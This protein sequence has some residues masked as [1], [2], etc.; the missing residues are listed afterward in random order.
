[1]QITQPMTDSAWELLKPRLLAQHARAEKQ[2]REQNMIED[3]IGEEDNHSPKESL[4]PSDKNWEACQT[5]IRKNLSTIADDYI[6]TKWARGK[7]ITKETAPQFA[8]DLLCHVRRIFYDSVV[9]QD[10]AALAAGRPI[11]YDVPGEP[12]TRTLILENMKWIY[13]HKIKPRTDRFQPELFLCA[14]C[15]GS[16]KFYG[17][18]G[19]VQHFAAKHTSS[20]SLG[21]SVVH[22]RAEWPEEPMYKSDSG[23]ARAVLPGV[24]QNYGTVTADCGKPVN[25]GPSPYQYIASIPPRDDGFYSAPNPRYPSHEPPPYM[26]QNHGSFPPQ[27]NGY[28][29]PPPEYASYLPGPYS[30]T[31]FSPGYQPPAYSGPP[32]APY[33][34]SHNH[35]PPQAM[36]QYSPPPYYGH[37]GGP[38]GQYNPTGPPPQYPSTFPPHHRPSVPPVNNSVPQ[39]RA[40]GS[41]LYAKQ[42]D[43]MAK[44]AREMW[45]ATNGIK[46]IPQSVRIYAVIHHMSL[47]YAALYQAEPTLAMFQEGLNNDAKMRPVRS[48]NGIGCN[49]CVIARREADLGHRPAVPVGIG[50][51]RLFTLPLLLNHFRN[52]HVE[53][54]LANGNLN[55]PDWKREMIELPELHVISELID[56]VGMDDGKLT[57]LAAAFPA[58]FPSPLPRVGSSTIP[59]SANNLLTNGLNNSRSVQQYG[60]QLG[61]LVGSAPQR[62]SDT[63]TAQ[64]SQPLLQTHGNNRINEAPREDE[65]DPHR[66]AN[67]Q[68]I[69]KSEPNS[70]RLDGP[71]NNIVGGD[72]LQELSRNLGSY[73]EKYHKSHISLANRDNDL[74][75]ASIRSEPAHPAADNQRHEHGFQVEVQ[76]AKPSPTGKTQYSHRDLSNGDHAMRKFKIEDDTRAHERGLSNSDDAQPYSPK[77][78]INGS[79]HEDEYR[80]PS[81][82][83]A[84]NLSGNSNSVSPRRPPR[85]EPQDRDYRHEAGEVRYVHNPYGQDDEPVGIRTSVPRSRSRSPRPAYIIGKSLSPTAS[86]LRNGPRGDSFYR[87]ASPPPREETRSQR[88]IRYEYDPQDRYAYVEDSRLVE[89][90]PRQ[91]V[92]YVPIGGERQ[93]PMEHTRYVYTEPNNSRQR[94]TEYIHYDGA[95]AGD[96]IYEHNGQLYRAQAAHEPLGYTRAYRY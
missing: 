83:E 49:E 27:S 5:L 45:F 47:R 16:Y 30:H 88:L 37:N 40:Q 7:Q 34:P 73:Q 51:R 35:Y 75:Q 14:G 66:P 39:R 65:Y 57:L 95:Y 67:L 21:N 61:S 8:A 42:L 15:P 43:D 80:P 31:D 84:S 38:P 33:Y 23:L 69:I 85:Y 25:S 86:Q 91:R 76:Q 48:L 94:P 36:P 53:P 2:E 79:Q 44:F 29:P 68:T 71:A 24:S 4:D 58:A 82:I 90:P 13:D 96:S 6:N 60:N 52:H 28:G 18:E 55:A 74:Q 20:L 17:F 70:A 77:I 78:A 9:Q 12:P 89:P 63:F 81:R 26:Q 92:Q 3:E 46:D 93:Q 56:A 22:W 54:S 41:E 19:V 72:L 50:D 64:S 1:M 32:S 62:L 10:H 87:V 11:E 59:G